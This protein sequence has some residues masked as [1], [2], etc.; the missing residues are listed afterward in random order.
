MFIGELLLSVRFE[1]LQPM[2]T[3]HFSGRTQL[4]R[5]LLSAMRQV[6]FK[7]LPLWVRRIRIAALFATAALLM[8]MAGCAG[9]GRYGGFGWTDT[10]GIHH[11][12]I[13][14]F[15]VVSFTNGPV[16]ASDVRALGVVIDRGFSA[17][18]VRRHDV[19]IDPSEA[20]NAVVAI[21]SS[22]LGLRVTNFDFRQTNIS[23]N[24]NLAEGTNTP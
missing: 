18:L 8:L 11:S 6:V 9:P 4:E 14:G 10:H 22:P 21:K 1:M 3:G 15:G 5:C 20:S 17:G 16:T 24:A 7:I 13:L 23:I 2:R 19:S 12:I